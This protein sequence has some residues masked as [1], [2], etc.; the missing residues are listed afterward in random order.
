MRCIK[1]G[2]IRAYLDNE[3]TDKKKVSI[4]MHLKKCEMCQK[5]LKDEK[6]NLQYMKSRLKL[7]DPVV[8]PQLAPNIKTLPVKKRLSIKNLFLTSVRI[9]AIALVI[10]GSIALFMSFI[11]LAREGITIPSKY[12]RSI[13][14]KENTL[15]FT[16]DNFIQLIPLNTNL[17]DFK[18]IQNPQIFVLKEVEER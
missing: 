8:T 17:K 15:T 12:L 11:V 4:E 14:A 18:P 16:A 9:P 2:K 1:S 6:N 7:I 10:L 5:M 13:E 3:M